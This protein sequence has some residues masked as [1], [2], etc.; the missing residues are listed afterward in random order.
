MT[1]TKQ[2]GICLLET[3]VAAAILAA[4]VMTVS[5]LSAKGLRSIRLNQEYEKAWD[6][7]DRQ[8]VLIDTAG[9]D[10][11]AEGGSASGQIESYDG[12]LWRWVAQ[13]QETEYA[14]LYDVVV[15]IEWMSMGQPKRIMCS[16]RL[17]GEPASIDETDTASSGAGPAETMR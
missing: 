11:L 15:Q 2:K 8:L 17:S 16:T 7:L 10:I 5:G 9:V 4:A 6:Y 3:V 14:G 12:R 1:V 13:A